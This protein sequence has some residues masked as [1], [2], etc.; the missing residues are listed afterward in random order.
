MKSKFGENYAVLLKTRF[1]LSA[2]TRW[3]LNRFSQFFHCWKKKKIIKKTKTSIL[4]ALLFS[5]GKCEWRIKS[6]P[7]RP[8]RRRRRTVPL[9]TLLL[10]LTFSFYMPPPSVITLFYLLFPSPP[11][12]YHTPRPDRSI[13]RYFPERAMFTDCIALLCVVQCLFLFLVNFIHRVVNFNI[14]G[15]EG[16]EGR[17]SYQ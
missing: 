11:A 8:N 14:R 5:S 2:L 9:L 7:V 1:I 6:P 13:D 3:N 16:W 15:L 12:F 17:R 10:R 4:K